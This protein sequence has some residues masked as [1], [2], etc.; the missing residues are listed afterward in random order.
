MATDLEAEAIR[1]ESQAAD[2]RLKAAILA[3]RNCTFSNR[4]EAKHAIQVFHGSLPTPKHLKAEDNSLGN[5]VTLRCSDERCAVNVSIRKFERKGAMYWGIYD[6]KGVSEEWTHGFYCNK[7]ASCPAKV[8]AHLLRDVTSQ[9]TELI[10][11]AKQRNISLGGSQIFD[12]NVS[13]RHRM[14]ASRVRLELVK[15]QRKD[16]DIMRLPGIFDEF[17]KS[18]PG[19]HAV[20]HVDEVEEVNVFKRCLIVPQLSISMFQCG[21]LRHLYAIDC[22][23]WSSTDERAYKLLL[24]YATTGNNQNC[25][26]AWAIVDG[27]KKENILW[28]YRELKL[29]GVDLNSPKIATI[30]DQGSALLSSIAE[31]LPQSFHITCSKH[32]LGNHPGSWGKDSNG[33]KNNLFWKLVSELK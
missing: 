18:N 26:V 9:G 29:A 19:S 20:Y 33:G 4:S 32:W 23:H 28:V 22:G 5:R 31:G 25:I 15:L 1:L 12:S 27:E 16:N 17:K 7:I 2:I 24:I 6:K 30:A 11:A 3:L 14:A 13:D 8:Q 21:Y 10:N